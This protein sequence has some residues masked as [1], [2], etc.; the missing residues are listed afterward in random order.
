[1]MFL[2]LTPKAKEHDK[3]AD[4]ILILPNLDDID[5][6][7]SAIFCTKKIIIIKEEL[8]LFQN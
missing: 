1:M 4:I 5:G 6:E 3:L 8:N 2:I 7:T